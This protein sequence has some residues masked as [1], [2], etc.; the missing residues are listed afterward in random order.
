[1]DGRLLEA[2]IE[3]KPEGELPERPVRDPV[4]Y[5]K[6]RTIRSGSLTEVECY[7][8]YV[9]PYRRSL[10]KAHPTQQAMRAVNDRN[11]K[12]RFERLMECNFQPGQDYFI[13][14]TYEGDAPEDEE[15]CRKDVR[16]YLNRVNRAREKAELEKAKYMGVIEIGKRGRLHHHLIIEGG[17]DRDEMER[18][19]RHGFANCDR[20]Q[21]SQGGMTA[22]SKYMTKGFDGK[23]EKG[24]HRYI[25]S[26][27]LKQPRITESRTR[28][29]RRQAERIREDADICGEAI[30]R[31]KYPGLRLE[32][33]TVRQ[34]DWL[35]G[36][37]IYA[38]MR[39]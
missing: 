26:R 20:I 37:Y 19:W 36:C 9:Y 29:S 27:G 18:L 31:K 13:T 25:Y 34:T 28:I 14:L 3:E 8:V 32:E 2:L 35:P 33:L 39:R 12:K 5:V 7:P 16:N 4:L 24:R 30:L 17:L 21:A 1:M 11:A 38:R 22:L 23:R 6:T 10:E 15:R